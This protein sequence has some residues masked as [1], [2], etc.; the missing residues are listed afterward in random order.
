MTNLIPFS[1]KQ[2]DRFFR[3]LDS[4]SNFN[5]FD[6]ISRN[7]Q[8]K[9]KNSLRITG[10]LPKLDI[11]EKDDSVKIIFSLHGYDK[12]KLKLTVNEEESKL[13]LTTGKLAPYDSDLITENDRFVINEI[14]QSTCQ[15]EVEFPDQLDL[16]AVNS[17]YKDG[18]LICTIPYKSIQ[19]NEREIKIG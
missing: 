6:T 7:Y 19:E 3:D 4:L 12:D 16:K 18:Y 17:E 2:F 11:I 14:K 15:R 13:T 5:F 10:T 8:T 1:N 9:R